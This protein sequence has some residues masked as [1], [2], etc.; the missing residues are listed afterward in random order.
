MFER[1]RYYIGRVV[2]NMRQTPVLTGATILTITVSLSI[3]ALFTLVAINIERLGEAWS[4][5]VQVVAYLQEP[6]AKQVLEDWRRRLGEL[7][8]VAEVTYVSPERA[9]E[10]FRD[11]LGQEKDLLRGVAADVLPASLEI[12]LVETSR[13]RQGVA[14]VAGFLRSEIGLEDLHYGQVWLE[15]FDSFMVLLRL[16]GMVLGAILL[17][18]TLFIIFNTIRLTLYSRR[19]ELDIMA[20]VGATPFFIKAPFVIEGALQGVAGGVLAL[21]FVW[22]LFYLFLHDGLQALLLSPGVFD[23]H[24]LSPALQA[25]LVCGGFLLGVIGSLGSLRKFVRV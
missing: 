7:P 16:S 8:E 19:D 21:G 24:F 10:L 13:N 25:A 1:L 11:R 5:E 9:F 18:A 4:S 12:A 2:A 20:L 6:P 23:V 3:V 22:T 14:A 17:A 15:K